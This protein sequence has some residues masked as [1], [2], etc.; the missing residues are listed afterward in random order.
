MLYTKLC[1]KGSSIRVLHVINN[2]QRPSASEKLKIH[3]C[4]KSNEIK[5]NVW[6]ILEWESG[7]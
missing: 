1:Y 5:R 2:I 3:Q 6:K 7:N 4:N